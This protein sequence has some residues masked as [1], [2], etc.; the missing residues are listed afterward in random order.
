MFFNLISELYEKRSV[1]IMG[2]RKT[3]VIYKSVPYRYM[4]RYYRR[5]HSCRCH[6]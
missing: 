1:I 5:S 4:A 2:G 3:V 6:M